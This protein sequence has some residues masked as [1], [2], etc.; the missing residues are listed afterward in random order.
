MRQAERVLAF[1]SIFT[2]ALVECAIFKNFPHCL[3]VRCLYTYQLY[4]IRKVSANAVYA[5]SRNMC[6]SNSLNDRPI[7]LAQI[8]WTS[9]SA[10]DCQWKN[11]LQKESSA[12]FDWTTGRPARRIQLREKNTMRRM[13][14]SHSQRNL[15]LPD[16]IK[17]RKS[18]SMKSNLFVLSAKRNNCKLTG[19]LPRKTCDSMSF[20]SSRWKIESIIAAQHYARRYRWRI[21]KNH[22]HVCRN[23][24][25]RCGCNFHLF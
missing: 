4:I 2:L 11:A 20:L 14:R 7:C 8:G 5:Y 10:L 25:G 12:N 13:Y 19:A 21:S 6:K 1:S 15:I 3:H 17:S 23:E 22:A 16:A 18:F 24:R 9:I